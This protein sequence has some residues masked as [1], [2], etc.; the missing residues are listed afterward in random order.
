MLFCVLHFVFV[1]C[2]LMTGHDWIAGVRT[3][4]GS[5]SVH[6]HHSHHEFWYECMHIHSSNSLR[7]YLK[8]KLKSHF[9]LNGFNAFTHHDFA[10]KFYF[11]CQ[12]STNRSNTFCC[13]QIRRK[14][15]FSHCKRT[16]CGDIVLVVGVHLPQIEFFSIGIRLLG[17]KQVSLQGKNCLKN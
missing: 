6:S 7:T 2:S 5:C 17:S 8:L 11:L 14:R 13:L 10:S 12:I 3:R 1:L 16:R 4:V 9:F 15:K